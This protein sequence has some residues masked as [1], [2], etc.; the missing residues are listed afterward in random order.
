VAVVAVSARWWEQFLKLVDDNQLLKK[1][2]P[3]AG[4]DPRNYDMA[5]AQGRANLSE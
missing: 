4:L 3:I 5:L 2:D 1:G